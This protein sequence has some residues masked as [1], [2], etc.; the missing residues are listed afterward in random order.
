MKAQFEAMGLAVIVLLV[1]LGMLFLLYFSFD[2]DTDVTERYNR[3]QQSQNIINALLDTSVQD[4]RLDYADLIEDAVV[5]EQ[6]PCGN[7]TQKLKEV[8]DTILAE[9]LTRRATQYDFSIV[10][11]HGTSEPEVIYR[12]ST[13][14]FRQ[15]ERD[16]A[17]VRTLTFYPAPQKAVVTLSIC[18]EGRVQ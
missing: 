12:N 3:E 10:K 17:G 5:W 2:D 6:H 11:Q 1:S 16:T 14:T 8:A 13:C 18:Y 7:S 15:T 4:C 9:T